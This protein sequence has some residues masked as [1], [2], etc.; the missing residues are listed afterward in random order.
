MKGDIMRMKQRKP[1]TVRGD[2]PRTLPD[3]KW[4]PRCEQ[5]LPAASFHISGSVQPELS[6]YCQ[7]CTRKYMRDRYHRIKHDGSY[8]RAHLRRTYNISEDEYNRLLESQHG[9]CAIC[10]GIPSG[11]RPLVVDHD[12]RTGTVRGLLCSPCNTGLG[13][14]RDSRIIMRTAMAYLERHDCDQ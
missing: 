3:E 1:Y 8:H 2:G 14:F 9:V 5:T 7:D 6:A 10:C 4:C 11:R 12:H 13:S